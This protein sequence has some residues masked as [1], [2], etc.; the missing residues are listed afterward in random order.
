MRLGMKRNIF[1]FGDRGEAALAEPLI[2]DTPF[3]KPLES[4]PLVLEVMLAELNL[5][6]MTGGV[7]ECAI[8][9]T[10]RDRAD[11]REQPC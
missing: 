2:C 6:G 3:A 9:D 5:C 7:I 8:R 4:L 11:S 10:V 1:S